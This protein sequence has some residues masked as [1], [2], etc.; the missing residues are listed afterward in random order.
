VNR[1][2]FSQ[3]GIDGLS[4]GLVAAAAVIVLVVMEFEK[5][6]CNFLTYLKYDTADKEFDEV[7]DDASPPTTAFIPAEVNRFGKNEMTK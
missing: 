1:I 5:A 3:S 7:F 2:I 4:W 6:V